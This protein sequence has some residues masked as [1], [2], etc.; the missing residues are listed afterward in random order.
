MEQ[1]AEDEMREKIS[2]VAT[3]IMRLKSDTWITVSVF[4]LALVTSALDFTLT[5]LLTSQYCVQRAFILRYIVTYLAMH[6]RTEQNLARY[7]NLK[8]PRTKHFPTLSV[9]NQGL[10]SKLEGVN[11]HL[12]DRE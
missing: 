4:D 5:A 8:N 6:A 3:G 9:R 12:R 1:R 7:F 10:Y 2:D 11:G